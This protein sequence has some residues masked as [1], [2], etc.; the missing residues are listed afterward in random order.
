MTGASGFVGRPLLGALRSRG[1]AVG[2]IHIELQPPD[3]DAELWRADLLDESSLRAA[4]DGFRP[5]RIVHMAGL[6]HVGDSFGQEEHYEQV[7]VHGTERLLRAAG[8]A[9]VILA[10]SSEVY[11]SVPE[12]EQPIPE[13]REPTPGSPYAESKVAAERLVLAG[14]GCVVRCF[15]VVGP[16]QRPNFA[17]PSFAAQLAAIERQGGSSH[18]RVGNLEVRRDFVPLPDAVSGYSVVTEHG[19]AGATYNLGIGRAERLRDL[20]ESLIAISGLEVGIRVDPMRFR[21]VDAEVLV[22][23]SGRLREL[24]WNPSGDLDG[25]L[26]ELWAEART[27]ATV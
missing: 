15:N 20:V 26:R 25:V 18:L 21:E 22:S 6:S 16:G 10:S 17:L 19:Q 9:M 14:G 4:I 7:N 12:D 27:Q 11:G 13:T 23:D 3:L 1:H 5:D 2:A 24:G 8:E